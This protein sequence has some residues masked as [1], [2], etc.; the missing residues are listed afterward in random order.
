MTRALNIELLAFVAVF[1]C[2]TF[3]QQ[4]AC[5][6][7]GLTAKALEGVWQVTKVVQ[8]G[9]VNTNPQP[10]L[11]IFSR[12]YYSALRVNGSEPRTQAPAPKDPTHLT[13]AEKIALYN[14]WAPYAAS[15]GTYEVKGN[16]IINHNVVAKMVRGMTIT[17]EAIISNFDGNSFV[18]RPKPGNPNSDRQTTYNRVK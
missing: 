2:F 8:A 11:Y 9:V 15:A 5:A 3:G 6:Q 16:T 12:G 13:D 4:A 18:A 7:E 1:C 14:E 17:E 10:S